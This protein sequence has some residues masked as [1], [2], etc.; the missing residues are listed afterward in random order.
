M[1]NPD[2]TEAYIA[3]LQT[4]LAEK[5]LRISSLLA[6]H[7]ALSTSL[8]TP[9]RSSPPPSSSRYDADVDARVAAALEEYA[10]AHLGGAEEGKLRASLVRARKKIHALE[11]A[12]AI[13]QEGMVGAA[14]EA[15]AWE[16]RALAAEGR[17]E[18][19]EALLGEA[20]ERAEKAVAEAE[21]AL[22]IAAAQALAQAKSFVDE[23]GT[24]GTSDNDL[25]ISFE[26]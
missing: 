6:T 7:A 2:H 18:E 17:V 3:S 20:Q 24:S 21:D 15:S 10:A 13:A 8:Q 25:D 19:L 26:F 22:P 11:N 4:R 23:S 14:A 9:P 12:L 16:E 5:E 1:A